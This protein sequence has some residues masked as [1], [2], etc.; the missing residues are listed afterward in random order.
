MKY[1][2]KRKVVCVI[3]ARY[4][5]SRFPGKPLQNIKGKPLIQ[6]VYENAMNVNMFESVVVATDDTRIARK[7]KELDINYLI[8]PEDCYT[9]T[10]RIARVS[11]MIDADLY[12]NLQGDE[13]LI[14]PETIK[15][16]VSSIV[17]KGEV[18]RIAFN[19]ITEAEKEDLNNPNVPKIV[20]NVHGDMLYTSRYP[21]PYVKSHQTPIFFK[22]LGLHAYTKKGL[23]IFSSFEQGALERAEQ[24]EFLRFLEQGKQVRLIHITLPFKNHAIDIPED[25]KVVKKIMEE[26]DIQ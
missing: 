19:A 14:M 11:E 13:C 1:K 26:Q 22:E 3:P 24:I 10:D 7:C 20:L 6:R 4:K 9:G 8:T 15:A 25:V 12:V 2:G 16:F 21:I 18:N 23:S 5:S 17:E